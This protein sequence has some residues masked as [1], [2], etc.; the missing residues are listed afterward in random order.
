[1][2]EAMKLN[3]ENQGYGVQHVLSDLKDDGAISEGPAQEW[4][5]SI[6]R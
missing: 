2:L 4:V 6:E 1:M 5:N 3:V